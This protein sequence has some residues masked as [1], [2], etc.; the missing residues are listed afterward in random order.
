MPIANQKSPQTTHSGADDRESKFQ[1]IF[2]QSSDAI[3]MLEPDFTVDEA[4]MAFSE[5]TGYLISDLENSSIDQISPTEKSRLPSHTRPFSVQMIESPGTHE[6]VAVVRKD[7][8]VRVVD[9]TVREVGGGRSGLSVILFRDVTEKKLMER[10]LITKHSALKGAYAQLEESNASLRSTQESLIQAGKMAALGELA[11]GIAHELNQPLMGIRGYAQELQAV[12]EADMSQTSR[13]HLG[14]IVKNADKMSKII[15]YLRNFTSKSTEGYEEVDVGELIDESLKMMEHQFR[16]HGV[17]VE[18]NFSSDLPK[19]YANPVQLEQVFINLSTNARDAIREAN[20]DG[21]KLSV[22][23]ER[24][25]N[26]VKV[27]Y[28]DNG[29]G[30]SETTKKKIMNPFYTTKEV[31]RGMGLGMSLSYGIL[32]RI[33]ASIVVKSEMGKGSEFCIQIP[34]DFRELG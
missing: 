28:R 6:D 3:V 18:T 9:M 24:D 25:G 14:E 1:E 8:Y 23:T 29:C 2:D 34:I 16:I 5:M 17:R 13:E 32:N 27:T 22:H 19:V 30:M 26:L 21:G 31:G 20:R 12:E 10:E 33:H 4:N 7:G 15:H 11:A